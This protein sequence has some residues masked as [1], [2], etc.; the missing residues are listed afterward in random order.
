M[1]MKKSKTIVLVVLYAFILI[2]T[3]CMEFVGIKNS[4]LKIMVNF[5]TILM[6]VICL[7]LV[8]LLYT[9]EK[10]TE[11]NGIEPLFDKEC[12]MKF[13]R[14]HSFTKRE[15]EIGILIANGYSNQ[16]IADEL[17]ISETTVKKHVTHI[18]EKA[19]VG[20]RKE[21]RLKIQL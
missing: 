15:T 11:E 2:F 9:S 12:Y 7:L 14:E 16:K 1:K 21:F 17:F 13:A 5:A 8:K 6:A 4:M 19:E 3:L 10:K 20:G 18:Y